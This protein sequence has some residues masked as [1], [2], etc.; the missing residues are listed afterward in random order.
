MT[1]I[2][3]ELARIDTV[4]YIIVFILKIEGIFII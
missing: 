2:I 1:D 4:K 3:S